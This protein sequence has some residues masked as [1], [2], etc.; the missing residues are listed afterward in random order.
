MEAS[1]FFWFYAARRNKRAYYFT[2]RLGGHSAETFFRRPFCYT[3][4]CWDFPRKLESSQ[5]A[6][7]A[8]WSGYPLCSSSCLHT[9]KKRTNFIYFILFFPPLNTEEASAFLLTTA[10]NTPTVVGLY[11]ENS[12]CRLKNE[13]KTTNRFGRYS[14]CFDRFAVCT[15]Y[16]MFSKIEKETLDDK[17]NSPFC[18][19]HA[20]Q[21]SATFNALL[22][23]H[24]QC[25]Y[26][27]F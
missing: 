27:L 22:N 1:F 10:V 2:Y 21:S 16:G 4:M 17:K 6:G 5:P 3:E 12:N 25:V 23:K 9:H 8:S 20:T 15:K 26:V 14:V 11:V 18:V 24:S 7:L 13:K 19:L